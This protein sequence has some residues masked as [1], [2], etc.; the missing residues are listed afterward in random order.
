[1]SKLTLPKK[2][3]TFV[4][5]RKGLINICPV[6]RSC[7]QEE[8]EEFVAYDEVHLKN[9]NILILLIIFSYINFLFYIF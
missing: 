7:S 8:R 9:F 2:R 4:E 3:G 5:F 1:M 6:G